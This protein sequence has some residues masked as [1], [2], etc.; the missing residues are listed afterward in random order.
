VILEQVF[1]QVIWYFLACYYSFIAVYAFHF[2][3]HALS[4]SRMLCALAMTRH[5]CSISL[6]LRYGVASFLNWHLASLG[7]KIVFYWNVAF[8]IFYTNCMAQGLPWT[9]DI[10]VWLMKFL[11]MEPES[12]HHVHV[13]H[14]WTP[15][16]PSYLVTHFC[17]LFC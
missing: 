11:V 4:N 8:F 16:S 2:F 5:H 3:S 9:F 6:I 10:V 15:S 7:Q 17:N 14:H 1:L 13:A 12:C